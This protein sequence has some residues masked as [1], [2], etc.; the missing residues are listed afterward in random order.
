MQLWLS[1]QACRKKERVVGRNLTTI[2]LA[3]MY[4]WSTMYSCQYRLGVKSPRCGC[5]H[6]IRG[7]VSSNLATDILFRR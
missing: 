7:A 3:G 6:Q 1:R 4:Y 2:R 5:V